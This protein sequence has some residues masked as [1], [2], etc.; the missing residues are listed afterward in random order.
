MEAR[1]DMVCCPVCDALHSF[2]DI[3]DGERARCVRCNTVIAVGRPEAILRIVVLASTALILMTIVIFYP[4]LELRSGVF[5]SKASVFETVM[6]FSQGVMA[7]LSLAVAAFVIVLPVARLSLLIWALG[8]LSVNRSPW[9][10]AARA[11]R[12]ADILKPWAMAEIFMV[13][14]AVALVKLADL[15][16]LSMG[17]AFWSFTAIV[18]ITAFKDTQMSKHSVWTALETASSNAR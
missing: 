13:G 11:L 2:G 15:A 10:G 3:P 5:G 6:S 9:P 17:P 16:T 8:P 12:Y 7:P 14:V 18:V 4:F 1:D